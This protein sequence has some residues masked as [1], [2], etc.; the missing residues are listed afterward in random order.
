MSNEVK[1]KYGTRQE[2]EN[3][4]KAEGGVDSSA[5][6]FVTKTIAAVDEENQTSEVEFGGTIYRGNDAIGTTCADHLKTTESIEVAGLSGKLGAGIANGDIIPAGTSLQEILVKLLSKEL[7]PTSPKISKNGSISTTYNN[8]SFTIK[9]ASGNNVPS[10][11]EVG[12][13]VTV[14]KCEGTSSYV[15][16]STGREFSGFTYGYALALDGDRVSD[17]N[18]STVPVTGQKPMAGTYT[19]TRTISDFDSSNGTAKSDASAYAD[20]SISSIELVVKEATGSVK[21]TMD[22][23]GHEGKIASTP[24]YYACSNLKNTDASLKVD[25]QDASTVKDTVASAGTLTKTV[26]G[27]YKYFIGFYSDSI[28]A[29]KKYDTTSIRT[30]DMVE[31]NWMDGKTISTRI[32]VPAG[33]R[34]MYI[35]IPTGVDDTGASLKVKQVNTNADV[36]EEMV[37]NKRPLQLTCGGTHK[38]DY[39]IF[40]WS[41]PGG[42]TGNEPFEITS[43]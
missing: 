36:N 34:G 2:Y 12:T 24:A 25:A 30:T 42:T 29:D 7:W 22:G 4:L 3:R 38:K 31:S 13:V 21:F 20:C 14:S 41:F 8:P 11:V 1:F 23:P 39:V 10:V 18:P 16:S 43:F 17:T 32:T 5:L 28:F 27:K 6:Y 15:S 37:E 26:E 33:T 40:T 19:L 35:A 9:D